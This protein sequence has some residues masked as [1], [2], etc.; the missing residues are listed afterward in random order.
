MTTRKRETNAE[1]VTRLM[2]FSPAGA[3]A[4]VFIITAIDAY[5]QAVTEVE[6]VDDTTLISGEAWK[7][8]AQCIRRE[9]DVR[10]GRKEAGNGVH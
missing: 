5:T 9:L 10:L 2:E 1:F 3:L 6:H 7:Q 8:V 4:Q